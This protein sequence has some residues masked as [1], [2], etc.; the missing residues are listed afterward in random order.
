MD[1]QEPTSKKEAIF[2]VQTLSDL[3]GELLDL[4]DDLILEWEIDPVED[5]SWPKLEVEPDEHDRRSP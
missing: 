1:I 2:Q 4:V 5:L 3:A